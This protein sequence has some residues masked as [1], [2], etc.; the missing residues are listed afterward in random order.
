MK[1]LSSVAAPGSPAETCAGKHEWTVWKSWCI[2][3]PPEPPRC[4]GAAPSGSPQPERES[5][6]EGAGCLQ[7]GMSYSHIAEQFYSHIFLNLV[8]FVLG[9]VFHCKKLS[10]SRHSIETLCETIKAFLIWPLLGVG[11]ACGVSLCPR[12]GGSTWCQLITH[13]PSNTFQT[14]ILY[15]EG[16][17]NLWLK[18]LSFSRSVLNMLKLKK[19]NLGP[20]H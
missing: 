12:Q 18:V 10:W 9:I 13:S 14:W 6:C 1:S 8:W 20:R 16:S 19:V 7:E 11:S 17:G 3:S 4:P 5:H 15:M 2:S